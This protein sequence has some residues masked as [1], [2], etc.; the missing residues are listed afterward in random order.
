MSTDT[1][2]TSSPLPPPS[3]SAVALVLRVTERE[4]RVFASVWRGTVFSTF[5]APLLFLVAL[6]IGLGDLITRPESLGDVPYLQFIAPGLMVGAAA[7]MGAGLS[8]WPIM[9]GH[10]WLG[11]HRAMV[12]SP[13]QAPHIAIGYLLFIGLRALSQGA[14]FVVG[15]AVLGAVGSG[16]APVAVPVAALTAMAMAAPAMAFTATQDSDRVFDPIMRVGVGPLYLFSGVFFPSESLP[17]VL[18]WFVRLFPL[19]HG[20]ELA[21]AATAGQASTWPTAVHLAVMAVWLVGGVLI[22][23]R[24]FVGRLTP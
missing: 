24:T 7:Q 6:G 23:R 4:V 8:L 22:A 17:I 13:I 16:W 19:W 1:G 20:V 9:A 2:R 18:E 3:A 21:R 12:T 5:V 15:A 11:F 14:V 10:R